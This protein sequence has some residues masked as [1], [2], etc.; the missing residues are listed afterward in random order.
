MPNDFASVRAGS[1][2]TVKF[3]GNTSVFIPAGA[4]VL[5]D[6]VALPITAGSEISLSLYFP[7]R[8]T[9]PTLH[10]LALKRTVVS[11]RGDHSHEATIVGGAVSESLIL[12]S[13]V[14]VPARPSQRLIVALGDSFTDG[15]GSTLDAD[16][17]WPSYL[18]R[19][20]RNTPQSTDVAVVNAGIAGNR[21]LS[22]GFGVS[23]MARFDRDVL[24]VPGVTHF[25][26][27]E[28]LNDIA[29]PGASLGNHNLPALGRGP[30]TEDLIAGYRQLAI[31]A[32]IKG[33][34]VIGATICPFAGA[35]IPGY[36]SESKEAVR[37]A[38]NQW[39]RES[40]QFDA[41]VDFDVVLRDPD[42]PNH[43]SSR[44][45]SGDHLHPNDAG[46]KAMA[47]AIDLADF[48]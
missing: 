27:F 35:E 25:V 42:H 11:P 43:M 39:I 18:S 9:T 37:Q 16:N 2:R 5:S 46:Y 33:I 24:S 41:V 38:L 30:S 34:K 20:L 23:A 48:R 10:S 28:G 29:F 3:A 45:L 13:A 26:L 15:D 4:P 22:D 6:P 14:L 17:T 40:G 21:L 32:H 44:F 31:R 47:D 8:V 36:Y 1:I 12:V 19:R 7:E